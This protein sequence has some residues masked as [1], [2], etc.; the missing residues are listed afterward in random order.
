MKT[1]EEPEKEELTGGG[2][3]QARH[4]PY[5]S[6]GSESSEL[7]RPSSAFSHSSISRFELINKG[8]GQ[9]S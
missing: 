7:N 1:N 4:P 9:D 3:P 2:G 5:Y 8:P 6:K